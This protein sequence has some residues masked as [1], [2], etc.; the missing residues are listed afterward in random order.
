MKYRQFAVVVY[1]RNFDGSINREVPPGAFPVVIK[2]G[3]P[4]TTAELSLE[5]MRALAAAPC[6]AEVDSDVFA[7]QGATLPDDCRKQSKDN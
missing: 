3:D 2:D 6:D 1:K 4:Q 5:L 7:R